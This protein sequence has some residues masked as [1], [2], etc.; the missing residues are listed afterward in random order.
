MITEMALKS[1]EA[2]LTTSRSKK[3]AQAH[4]GTE[5]VPNPII[6]VAAQSFE[7]VPLSTLSLFAIP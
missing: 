5:L 3:P 7:N 2:S 4:P 6:K 1:F